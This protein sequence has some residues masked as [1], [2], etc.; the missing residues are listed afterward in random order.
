MT[1]STEISSEVLGNIDNNINVG[2]DEVVNVFI[3]Q[4]EE[5][6]FRKKDEL[7][8]AITAAKKA[9]TKHEKDEIAVQRLIA[10]N[11]YNSSIDILD[12]I[13]TVGGI[14]IH[15]DDSNNYSVPT[16]IRDTVTYPCAT[17]ELKIMC[18]D[19]RIGGKHAFLPINQDYATQLVSLEEELKAVTSELTE[20]LNLIG[21]I[22]RKERA[23]RGKISKSKLE[24]CG[25]SE[26]IAHPELLKLIQLPS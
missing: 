3:S 17:F 4:Y 2:M 19:H 23:I 18:G 5:E 6:L 26:L 24:A 9:I 7:S 14:R 8:I 22:N 16:E 11:K 13:I 15:I 1:K 12:A 20:I 25:M 10:E 21:S